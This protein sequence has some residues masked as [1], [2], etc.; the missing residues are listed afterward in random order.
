MTEDRPERQIRLRPCS[1]REPGE[2]SEAEDLALVLQ[3]RHGSTRYGVEVGIGREDLET[4]V[5]ASIVLTTERRSSAAMNEVIRIKEGEGDRYVRV[6]EE[7]GATDQELA[8]F[9]HLAK[10]SPLGAWMAIAWI[11]AGA[12]GVAEAIDSCA[13][14]AKSKAERG[15]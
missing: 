3:Y 4:L 11:E 7:A 6:L 9:A 8:R 10:R 13:E 14:I 1:W 15:I 2:L 12:L 5:D